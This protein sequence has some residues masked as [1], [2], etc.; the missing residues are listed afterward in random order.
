[1]LM[2]SRGRN[3]SVKKRHDNA[4]SGMKDTRESVIFLLAT[5][6]VLFSSLIHPLLSAGLAL[7]IMGVLGVFCLRS[8]DGHGR[9][10]RGR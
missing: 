4:P 2:R 6:L 5:M 10:W 1:M 7:G 8:G 3:L 9:A